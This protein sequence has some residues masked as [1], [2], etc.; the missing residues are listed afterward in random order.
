MKYKCIIFDCDGVLVD[1]EAISTSI[2]IEMAKPLGLHID[3]GFATRQFSGK[4]L[5]NCFNFIEE[6]I[7]KKLPDNFEKEF[8]NKTFAAFK[9]DIKPIPGIHE[10]LNKITIPYC[11]ASSGPMEKIQLNLTTT[12]LIDK[13]TNRMFSAYDIG[14][15]K[16]DP[17]IFLHAANKMGFQPNECVVIEDSMAG[18]E[19]ANAGGFDVYAFVNEGHENIFENT[20]A[21]VFYKMNELQNLLNMS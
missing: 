1:S 10:L 11:V 20:T 7:A 18:V 2:L 8:R 15:W 14:K 21:A 13:F 3:S 17:G 5:Q 16:P 4:S 9:K 6:K 19:A 12:N